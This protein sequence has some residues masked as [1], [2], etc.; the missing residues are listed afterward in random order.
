M[1]QVIEAVDGVL[2]V[3]ELQLFEYDLRT[4]RRVGGGRES[5]QLAEYALFLAADHKVVVR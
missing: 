1:T 4:G 2:A 3:D 5:I